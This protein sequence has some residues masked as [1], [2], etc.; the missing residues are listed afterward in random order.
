[1]KDLLIE[2]CLADPTH[3]CCWWTR[4]IRWWAT[5]CSPCCANCAPATSTGRGVLWPQRAGEPSDLWQRCV[6]ECKVLRSSDRKSLQGTIERG[7][8]QTLRYMQKC[9]A[10]E[11]HLMLFD[12]RDEAPR[13]APGR[14][15]ARST[16]QI[17]VWTL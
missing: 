10:T 17:A 3:W 4:S 5:R 9:R 2:W 14:N 8:E 7:V 13:P 16:G 1:M 12:R 15:E 11:G 6:I